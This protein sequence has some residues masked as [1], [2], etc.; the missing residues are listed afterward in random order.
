M[1]NILPFRAIRYSTSLRKKASKLLAPPYDVISREQKKELLKNDPANAI[2][3]IVGNPSVETHRASDYAAAANTLKTWRGKGVLDRDDQPSLYVYQ[4]RFKVEGRLYLR[5]GFLALSRLEPF[6]RSK[7]GILAHEF[8][9]AGPKADRLNLMKKA[10]ANFSPIF[11]LYPDQG[12]VG[13]ILARVTAERPEMVARFPKDVETA[14]GPSATHRPLPPSKN[15]CNRSPC[16]SPMATIVM[17]PPWPTRRSSARGT[18]LPG[19]PAL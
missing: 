13:K 9:L 7:G 8:T 4:Q 18:S 19:F 17:R 12:G 14:C 6:G 1:A 15:G 2:R 3:L 5:T 16:S 10:N 11:S